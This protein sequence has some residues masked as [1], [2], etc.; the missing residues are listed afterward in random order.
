MSRT[1]VIFVCAS[2]A[3][4]CSRKSESPTPGPVPA[5]AAQT[6]LGEPGPERPVEPAETAAPSPDV[7]Q[8]SDTTGDT[9]VEEPAEPLKT[10]EGV[11]GALERA[12]DG[13]ATCDRVMDSHLLKNPAACLAPVYEA[14]V[15]VR[16]PSTSA[17]PDANARQ[18]LRVKLA[19]I[20]SERVQTEDS[21]LLLYTLQALGSDFDDTPETRTRLEALMKHE[22]KAIASAAATARLSKPSAGDKATLKLATSLIVSEYADGVRAAACRYIG[23]DVFKGNRAHV[24]LLTGRAL[25]KVEAS[26]V[27]GTAVARLGFIGS[28]ADIPTL[29]RLFRVPA[30][31]YAAVF[32]IQQGLRSAKAFE[33]VVTWLESQP[34]VSNSVQWGTLSAVTPRPD[35]VTKFPTER[36]IN[37]LMALARSEVQHGRTRSAAVE[38]IVALGGTSKLSALKRL[39]KEKQDPDSIGVL[40]AVQK[41]Q[42]APVKP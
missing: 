37:A 2:F 17:A 14:R 34:K 31:Q 24:K 9:T 16:N 32:T 11:I 36:G 23:S 13:L 27:R 41:A 22:V 29:A 35:D 7:I 26:V 20:A 4:A 1:L 30:T 5:P 19:A 21:T 25:A 12:L 18:A 40:E 10:P 28:D 38:A 15:E 42:T 39:L 3:V 8:V 33:A 6:P